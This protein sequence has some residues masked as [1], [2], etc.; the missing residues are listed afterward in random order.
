MKYEQ[1]SS[2]EHE[3]SGEEMRLIAILREKGPDDAE[4]RK[5]L[6]GWLDA[7]EAKVKA[8]DSP[9]ANVEFSLKQ[10]RLYAAAGGVESAFDNAH[11]ALYEAVNLRDEELQIQARALCDELGKQL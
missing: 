11:T 10:A 3:F 4:A 7:E 8:A 6:N 9:R 1:F 5:L 2:R